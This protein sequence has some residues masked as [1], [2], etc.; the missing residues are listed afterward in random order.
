MSEQK[1]ALWNDRFPM[2]NKYD[3]DWVMENQMGP[4]VLW[5]AEWLAPDMDLKPGMRV[6]D[7][8]CG[9]AISSIFL[10]QNFGL[11]V[12]AV[13]LWIAANENWNRIR[14]A[15]LS[16]KIFPLHIEAHALPFAEEFFDAIVSLDAYHYFGTD[17]MYLNYLMRFLKP[18][19]QFGIVVP[20]L[21]REFEDG[22]V[23]EH[24]ASK[25]ESGAQ[26]WQPA[27]CCSIRTLPW[28]EH[29]WRQTGL[30]QIQKADMLE[31][32]AQLWAEFLEALDAAGKNRFPEETKPVR[33]DQGR[34]LGFVR[35][36]A[37]KNDRPRVIR[38]KIAE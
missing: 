18:G 20:A 8:G 19:G 31:N 29:H 26:W 25:D 38:D 17:T 7:L 9:T 13:D 36:L 11:Q 12:W 1:H 35:L 6:L 28:W 37:R 14:A 22:V 4:N 2:S 33:E 24:L 5:L 23:P 15:G 27:D 10:A 34:C 32:G 16:D 21:T 30:V 3:P